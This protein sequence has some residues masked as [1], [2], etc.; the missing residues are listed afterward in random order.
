MAK[1]PKAAR[2]SASVRVVPTPPKGATRVTVRVRRTG[3]SMRMSTSEARAL[4]AIGVV[5]YIQPNPPPAPP[6]AR[7]VYARRDLTAA[8][9]PFAVNPYRVKGDGEA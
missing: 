4:H 6:A 1:T 7:P 8:V 2:T 3:R 9:P 5:E